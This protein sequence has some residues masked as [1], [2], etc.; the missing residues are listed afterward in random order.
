M[1]YLERAKEFAAPPPVGSPHSVPLP[2][3]KKPGRSAVYR[4]WR[5]QDALLKS[6]D[7]DITTAHHMF[8]E[9]ANRNPSRK[10]LGYRPF[11]P[12]KNQF[13]P[14]QWMDYRTVQK[15]RA[16]YGVGIVEANRQAGVTDRSYGVGL[17]CQNRPEWQLTGTRLDLHWGVTSNVA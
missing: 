7:P 2:N 17:W 16:N 12:V 8:E 14:Y 11:D 5:A 4:H 9:A 10:C 1:A 15:R 13:G 6:L 3:S